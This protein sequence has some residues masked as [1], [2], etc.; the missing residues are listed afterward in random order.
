MN[1]IVGIVLLAAAFG[2]A[3]AWAQDHAA[4]EGT[5]LLGLWLTEEGKARV[6]IALC[7]ETYCGSL[8]WIRDSLKNGLPALDVK[9]P[10]ETLRARRVLGMQ[11]LRDFR[12][13]GENVWKGGTVYDPESGNVY[14]AKMT[15][16]EDG[17][18]TLRGYVGIPLFGRSETWT[19]V[20]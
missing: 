5:R 8:V 15:L 4:T 6:E 11:F 3:P 14:S 20:H 13:D 12:Y 19:R 10:D 9:N 16:E 18:L 2:A 7:G 17:T 1:R